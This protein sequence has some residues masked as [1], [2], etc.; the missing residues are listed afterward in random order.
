MEN[1]CV[2]CGDLIPEGRMVC[3]SCEHKDFYKQS[4]DKFVEELYGIKLLPHQRLLL[5]LANT[6]QKI[7]YNPRKVYRK[8]NEYLMMIISLIN[9]KD[10]GVVCLMDKNSGARKMNKQEFAEYLKGYWD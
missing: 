1:R 2:C 5:K 7:F 6:K 8:W 4:P 10:D 9:M 3:W